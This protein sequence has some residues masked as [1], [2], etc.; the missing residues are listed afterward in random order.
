MIHAAVSWGD[1]EPPAEAGVPRQN[2][3]VAAW[4]AFVSFAATAE[5]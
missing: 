3:G 2:I 1:S 4:K 5:V